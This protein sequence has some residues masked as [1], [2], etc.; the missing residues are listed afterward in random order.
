MRHQPVVLYLFL[1]TLLMVVVM[2][3]HGAPLYTEAA[4][5]GIVSLELARTTNVSNTIISSWQQAPNA[6]L[7]RAIVNTWIDFVFIIAYSL[8]LF[9]CCVMLA[10]RQRGISHQLSKLMALAAL[11][12]GLCDVV[13]NACLLQQLETDVS[14][15]LSWCTW[16]LASIKF[17]LLA[18]VVLWCIAVRVMLWSNQNHNA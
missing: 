8:F 3:W 4:P 1:F 2:R 13:E 9:S 7:Q 5:M 10:H 12:A 17:L 18:L 6:V 14:A 15:L 16:L 11:T